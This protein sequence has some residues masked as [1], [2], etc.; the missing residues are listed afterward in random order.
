MGEPGSACSEE[1]NKGIVCK[2]QIIQ[3][4]WEKKGRRGC[5]NLQKCS[6]LMAMAARV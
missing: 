5:V 3:G 1:H 4:H 6:L 2:Q